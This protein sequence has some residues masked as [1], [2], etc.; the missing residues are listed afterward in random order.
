MAAGGQW[1]E[2]SQAALGRALAD[3]VFV[4]GHPAA[5]TSDVRETA[6]VGKNGVVYLPSEL[7]AGL[8]IQP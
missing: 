1:R 4:D 8:G 2:V 6:L 5:N 7:N 3:M